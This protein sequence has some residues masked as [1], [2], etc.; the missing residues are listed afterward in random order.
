MISSNTRASRSR[1]SSP[2]QPPQN[3]NWSSRSTAGSGVDSL[4]PASASD[5]SRALMH[6]WLEPSVQSK[7]SFEEAGLMRYG[8]LENMAPLGTMPKPKKPEHHPV[9]RIVLRAPGVNAANNANSERASTPSASAAAAATPPA[10]ISAPRVVTPPPPSSAPPPRKALPT[11]AGGGGGAVHTGDQDKELGSPGVSRRI[12]ARR[13]SAA[14]TPSAPASLPKKARRPSSAG[15]QKRS[16]STTAPKA[17]PFRFA[18]RAHRSESEDRDL[19]DKVVQEAVDEALRLC[20]Y[21]TA[22]ALKTL[23]E[24]KAGDAEFCSM[25]EDV[26]H[27]TA[28]VATAGKFQSMIAE[29]KR[30]GK[31]NGLGCDDFVRPTRSL[32]LSPQPAPCG[33]LLHPPPQGD[34]EA[35]RASKKIKISHAAMSTKTTTP[36]RKNA[37]CVSARD[38]RRPLR[39]PLPSRK[40]GRPRRI[41][42]SSGSSLSSVTSLSSPGDSVDT[43]SPP[44]RPGVGEGR[45]AKAHDR[46]EPRPRPIKTRRKSLAPKQAVSNAS[47]SISPTHPIHTIKTAVSDARMPGRVAASELFPNLSRKAARPTKDGGD[48]GRLHPQARRR[49]SDGLGGGDGD[50]DDEHDNDEDEDAFWTRRREARVLTEGHDA[51][52]SS[53]RGRA[54]KAAEPRS[55][56]AQNIRKTRQS[57]LASSGTRATRSASKRP[58]DDTDGA[59]SPVSASFAADSGSAMGSRAATPTTLRPSKKPRSGLR[60]KSSYV[61]CFSF[62][63]D[64]GLTGSGPSSLPLSPFPFPLS[65]HLFDVF[66]PLCWPWHAGGT[67]R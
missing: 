62:L 31:K 19:I 15:V 60:T 6:K 14:A 65:F 21:P 9:R 4:Q 23:Y 38:E 25:V 61:F 44:S 58:I 17:T 40:R 53:V 1:Y 33:A 27:Q 3:G 46:D 36:P 45:V 28:D 16:I 20:R 24:E 34:E 43:L 2:A 41:S 37:N 22:Y 13:A 10:K 12:R 55:T 29:R 56:P 26:F 7:S 39:G 42:H 18:A 57:I 47:G 50:V 67:L 49:E 48:P 54:D 32:R 11:R 52:E 8:V 35:P 59:S 64:A 51:V 5:A 30:E 66:L 63:L